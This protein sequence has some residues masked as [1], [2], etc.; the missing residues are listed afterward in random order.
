[1]G[2]KIKYSVRFRSDA[3]PKGSYVTT[4]VDAGS[5]SDAVEKVRKAHSKA[6]EIVAKPK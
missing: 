3:A 1:M 2:K 6:T 4:F 5:E